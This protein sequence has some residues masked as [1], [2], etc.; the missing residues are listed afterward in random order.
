MAAA[1]V[2]TN[3]FAVL[4]WNAFLDAGIHSLRTRTVDSK[5]QYGDRWS[6][7]G[8]AWLYVIRYPLGYGVGFACTALMMA[9]VLWA[10]IHRSRRNLVLLSWVVPYFLLVTFSPA[11]FMRYSA[12][13]IPALSVLAGELI[14]VLLLASDRWPRLAV[15]AGSVFA[16]LYTTGY[17]AAYAQLFTQTDARTQAAQ[18]IR[19]HAPAGSKIGFQEIPDGLLNLPYFVVRNRYQPCFSRFSLARLKGPAKYVVV[20]SYEKE[21]HPDVGTAQVEDFLT[22]LTHVPGYRRVLR[23]RHVPSL[24]PLTFSIADSPHDWRYPAHTITIYAHLVHGS[25][26]RNYCFPTLRK[27]LK[28]L[29]VPPPT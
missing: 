25:A 3:P 22:S 8:P 26:M 7:Y 10:L 19:L 24:G 16:L 1:W 18:W 4:Q 9:G 11:K 20:D 27:A 5:L 2:V 17:D 6:S 14:I 13:L 23:I 29:Y 21:A 12:P 15:L 28:V